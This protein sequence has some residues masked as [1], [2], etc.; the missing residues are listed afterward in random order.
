MAFGL[1]GNKRWLWA[2]IKLPFIWSTGPTW[3]ETFP[4]IMINAVKMLFVHL[5]FP[6][7]HKSDDVNWFIDLFILDLKQILNMYSQSSSQQTIDIFFKFWD[8]RLIQRPVSYIWSNL[9]KSWL[10]SSL[11]QNLN[12]LLWIKLNKNLIEKQVVYSDLGISLLKII[13]RH[14]FNSFREFNGLLCF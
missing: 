2:P 3:N 8:S 9:Q 7:Q 5:E 6:I 10:F 14:C 11:F 4:F 13:Q 1:H 12:F